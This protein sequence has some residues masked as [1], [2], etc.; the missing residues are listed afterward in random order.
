MVKN[1][2]KVNGQRF[3]S[4]NHRIT[5]SIILSNAGLEPPEDYELLYKINEKGY[6]PIQ[7]DEEVDLKMAG[8]E[9]FRARPYKALTIKVD[10]KNIEVEACF[11]TPREIMSLAG[12]NPDQFFLK[13]IRPRNVEVT[14]EDD[15]EHK[16][17][18][19]KRSCF[20]SCQVEK[21]ECIIV[22]A[23]EKPWDK[24]EISFEEVVRLQF[25]D[26]PCSP[27]VIFTVIYKKGVPSKPEGS[28][29]RGDV[30][31]VRNKM[32]FNVTQTNKS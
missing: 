12:I 15:I 1:I 3:E 20:V 25:G 14:Y 32:I 21:V 11:I 19:S 13:E 18:I 4:E 24:N 29:V 31:S 10:G 17:A 22:N 30:I 7:L 16:I 27:Q 9:G 2:Y 6:T 26:A 28:M 8:I 5:G 23:R